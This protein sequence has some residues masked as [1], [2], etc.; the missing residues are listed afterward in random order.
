M[1][2]EGLK[3]MCALG[4]SS[5]L[6]LSKETLLRNSQGNEVFLQGRSVIEIG[7]AIAATEDDLGVGVP[8][9]KIDHHGQRFGVVLKHQRADVGEPYL[10]I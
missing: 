4:D 5:R 1:D 7:A 10:V 2:A 9:R 8:A 3:Q 6:S